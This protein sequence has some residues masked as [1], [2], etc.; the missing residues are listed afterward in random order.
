M[1]RIYNW[2][3]EAVEIY[4]HGF[5]LNVEIVAHMSSCDDFCK[6]AICISWIFFEEF[7]VYRIKKKI[8]FFRA[9]RKSFA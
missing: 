7:K 3:C 2:N 8:V 5:V 6:S 9:K 4:I 1:Y